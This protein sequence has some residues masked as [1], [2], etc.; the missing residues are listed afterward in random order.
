MDGI[1][2]IVG[3]R[4]RELRERAGMTQEQLAAASGDLSRAYLGMLER[5]EKGVGLDTLHRIAVGLGV[6]MSEFF[7]A[8]DQ[9]ESSEAKPKP[10]YEVL[11]HLVASLAKKA[12]LR[13]IEKFKEIAEIF[14]GK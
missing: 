1:N 8:S 4:V 9:P 6:P 14:F 12:D 10:P 11:G 5:G 2:A 3:R 7:V 13:N